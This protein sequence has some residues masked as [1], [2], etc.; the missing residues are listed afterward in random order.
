M[1]AKYCFVVNDFKIKIVDILTFIECL[2]RPYIHVGILHALST[3]FPSFYLLNIQIYLLCCILKGFA[4][5]INTNFQ[6]NKD[7]F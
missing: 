1:L 5:L 2:I 6:I 4:L 3:H 7:L